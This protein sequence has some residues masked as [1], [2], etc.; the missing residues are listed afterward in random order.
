MPASDP[1]ATTLKRPRTRSVVIEPPPPPLDDRDRRQ[2][3][4]H[5]LTRPAK[6]FCPASGRFLAGQTLNI[7]AGGVL[8]E[9]DAPTEV[10]SEDELQLTIGFGDRFIVPMSELVPGKVV[11]TMASDDPS[12]MR[13]A[14]AY[15]DAGEMALSA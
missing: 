5:D 6:L 2:H 9:V 7:S 8:V 12:R 14:I 15:D 3:V 1:N 10:A 11:R 4:R 13:I